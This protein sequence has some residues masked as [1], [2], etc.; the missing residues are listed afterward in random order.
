MIKICA[1]PPLKHPSL[2][3]E[4]DII[5][6]LA[7]L[8]Y[9]HPEYVD[10]FAKQ[11]KYKIL[12]NSAAEG[13]KV[14]SKILMDMAEEIKAD[15]IVIPD[16]L[17][18]GW[19]TTLLARFFI[20]DVPKE[21]RDKYRWLICPQG[22]SEDEY[23]RCLKNILALPE[24]PKNVVIGV[25]KFSAPKCFGNRVRCVKAIIDAGITNEIHLLG[26]TEDLN[27]VNIL[28]Q[29]PQIRSNDSCISIL[30]ATEGI[31]FEVDNLSKIKRP[32]TT[33]EYFDVD[34]SMQQIE[35]AKHNIAVLKK[36]AN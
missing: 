19:K 34:M 15:E 18:V 9:K 10:F 5:F 16:E 6:C 14:S 12:D 25:S 4:G 20:R 30:A 26:T 21:K 2:S 1:I 28:K 13:C 31:K 24:C 3:L 29:Y 7:H 33:N 22:K 23:M 17:C 11:T 27:E 35:L 8:A 32:V 36:A